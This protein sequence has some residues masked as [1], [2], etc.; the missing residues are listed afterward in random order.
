MIVPFVGMYTCKLYFSEDVLP[1]CAQ[2]A[3]DEESADSIVVNILPTITKC[4]ELQKQ[5]RLQSGIRCADQRA[6]LKVFNRCIPQPDVY[7][8]VFMFIIGYSH[9]Y[10]W[11]PISDCCKFAKTDSRQEI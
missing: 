8:F 3:L 2:Y 7:I 6:L 5:S 11:H 10:A 9:Q 4:N 1:W